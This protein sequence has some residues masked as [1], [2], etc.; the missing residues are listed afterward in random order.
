[1]LERA[2]H[3]PGHHPRG[4]ISS[5]GYIGG[6][7]PDSQIIVI[8]RE[9]APEPD[10]F[11]EPELGELSPTEHTL[12]NYALAAFAGAWAGRSL[13]ETHSTFA[14]ILGAAAVAVLYG[15][16]KENVSV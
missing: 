15:A 5:S 7:Y 12:I 14:A 10:F 16:A 1:M 6:G 8:E 4:F 9:V 2:P 3:H 13:S 11:D